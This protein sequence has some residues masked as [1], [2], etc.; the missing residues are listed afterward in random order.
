ME[1]NQNLHSTKKKNTTLIV[2]IVILII[3]IIVGGYFAFRYY[4]D[5]T[6]GAQTVSASPTARQATIRDT[7]DLVNLLRYPQAETL[8]NGKKVSSS[9]IDDFSMQTE[10][11]VLVVY[12]YYMNL[13]SEYGWSLGDSQISSDQLSAYITIEESDFQADI[14]IDA[15]LDEDLTDINVNIKTG[16]FTSS[17]NHKY[18]TA[19]PTAT[20]SATVSASASATSASNSSGKTT[21]TTDYVISDS[22]T[23]IIETSEIENFSPWQ[24]KVARNEIYARHGREFVYEDMKCYF[25]GKSWYSVNPNFSESDLS[26]TEIQNISIILEQEKAIDSQVMS[27]DLGC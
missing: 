20:P 7:A 10:D 24:L 17:S 5:Q 9:Q 2:V 23:R 14:N 11:S 22:D 27:K 8:S 15:N 12:N 25:D 21:I 26:S 3:A 18:Q 1:I 19:V 6:N 16:E 4:S 13:L